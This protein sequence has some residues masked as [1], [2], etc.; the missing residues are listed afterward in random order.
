MRGAGVGC[1]LAVL[2][3]A[4]LGCA[5]GCSGSEGGDYDGPQLGPEEMI[6]NLGGREARL[7]GGHCEPDA[8]Q[9]RCSWGGE[10]GGTTVAIVLPGDTRPQVYSAGAD[11]VEVIVTLAADR[12]QAER[13]L[14]V[15][16]ETFEGRGGELEGE[17]DGRLNGQDAL[18]LF[19]AP[20][21]E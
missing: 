19:R 1:S 16:I 17:L 9:W 10:S 2:A 14:S 5:A 8:E 13:S 12:L 18:G 3:A 20:I 4:V 21:A 11:G 7:A 15:T 6:F